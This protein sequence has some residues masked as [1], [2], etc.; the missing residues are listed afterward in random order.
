MK[1]YLIYNTFKHEYQFPSIFSNTRK[2]AETMLYNAIGN[3][4]KKHRF[5]IRELEKDKAFKIREHMIN[6]S[7]ARKLKTFLPSATK[8]ELLNLV[9]K[10]K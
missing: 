4:A 9:I 6:K 5:E 2:G 7:I 1:I 3:D 10:Y 8:E